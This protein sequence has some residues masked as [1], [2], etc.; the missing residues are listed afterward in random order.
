MRIRIVSEIG[1]VGKEVIKAVGWLFGGQ[2]LAAGYSVVVE[3][4]GRA[5]R[6][7]MFFRMPCFRLLVRGS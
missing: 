5:G 3:S 6:P 7:S 2:S 1:G 4:F